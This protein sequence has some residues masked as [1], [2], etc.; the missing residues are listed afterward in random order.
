MVSTSESWTLS[1]MRTKVL[2]TGLPKISPGDNS[3]SPET[4]MIRAWFSPSSRGFLNFVSAWDNVSSCLHAQ[5]IVS[6]E[7]RCFIF[8]R[9]VELPQ[10]QQHRDFCQGNPFS[11]A[12]RICLSW[13]TLCTTR[14][15]KIFFKVPIKLNLSVSGTATSLLLALLSLLCVIT[16]QSHPACKDLGLSQHRV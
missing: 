14:R 10:Y 5:T 11:T 12:F 6:E 3:Y 15:L 2:D 9:M 7:N 1:W 13:R 8:S 4:K 16:A